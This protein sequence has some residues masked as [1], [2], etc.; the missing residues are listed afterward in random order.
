M[1]CLLTAAFQ[2]SHTGSG[3]GKKHAVGFVLGSL[4]QKPIAEGQSVRVCPGIQKATF[5]GIPS[6]S[7]IPHNVGQ[8]CCGSAFCSSLKS[9]AHSVLYYL[10]MFPLL[11]SSLFLWK[12]QLCL[13]WELSR[14][15][16]LVWIFITINFVQALSVM[17]LA[18]WK[19]SEAEGPGRNCNHPPLSPSLTCS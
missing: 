8:S 11:I 15:W 5:H 18:A 17:R 1:Q 7:F 10:A 9:P 12:T 6:C 16:T 4:V 2:T 3:N 14:C 19:C 13:L